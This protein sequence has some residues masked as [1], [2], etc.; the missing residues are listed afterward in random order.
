MHSIA[1]SIELWDRCLVFQ[2]IFRFRFASQI[3]CYSTSTLFLES[4]K[5]IRSSQ[6]CLQTILM[7]SV[8]RT[9]CMDPRLERSSSLKLES[10]LWI[11]KRSLK[12]LK[13]DIFW[14]CSADKKIA[15][16]S[17]SIGRGG[18]VTREASGP[19]LGGT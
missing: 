19:S 11:F 15:V 2:T 5:P 14:T 7:R 13:C 12:E 1:V 17:S 6:L 16:R 10:G 9:Q 4:C 3:L 8:H 18:C